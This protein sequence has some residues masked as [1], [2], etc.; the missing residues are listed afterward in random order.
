MNELIAV[1]DDEVDITNL[2]SLHLKKAKYSVLEFHDAAG[3]IKNALHSFPISS[4]STS[5]FP[6]ETASISA[7]T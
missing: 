1:V 4:F 6:T 7:R 3:F 2:V 5:C